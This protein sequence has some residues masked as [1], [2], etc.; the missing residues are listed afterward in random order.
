MRKLR[1]IFAM[2]GDPVQIVSDNDTPFTFREFGKFCNQHGIRHILS[3]PYHFATMEKPNGLSKCL[4]V[5][6]VR[7]P[8]LPRTVD[9]LPQPANSIQSPKY[10]VFSKISYRIPLDYQTNT[11]RTTVRTNDLNDTRSY[12]TSRTASY[13]KFLTS[14]STQSR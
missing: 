12:P 3:T 13:L 7:I 1:E 8:I 4:K 10:I 11:I 9:L 14:F 6:F 2:L 5:R